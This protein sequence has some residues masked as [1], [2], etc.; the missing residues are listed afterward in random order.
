[1]CLRKKVQVQTQLEAAREQRMRQRR[2]ISLQFCRLYLQ[3]EAEEQ[4]EEALGGETRS[5]VERN[6]R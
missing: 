4:F 1:M 2:E 6:V 3:C 5:P